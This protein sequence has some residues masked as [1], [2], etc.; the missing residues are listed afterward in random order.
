MDPGAFATRRQFLAVHPRPEQFRHHAAGRP[1]QEPSEH[2]LAAQRGPI[3]DRRSAAGAPTAWRGNFPSGSMSST[4]P[5]QAIRRRHCASNMT[6]RALS[7]PP[8]HPPGEKP[9]EHAAPRAGYSTTFARADSWRSCAILTPSARA[10]A[11]AR[12]SPSPTPPC[13]GRAHEQMLDDVN[14]PGALP[15]SDL[16]GFVPSRRPSSGVAAFPR[17]GGRLSSKRPGHAAAHSQY[18]SVGRADS[19]LQ[20]AE[21]AATLGRRCCDDRSHRGAVDGT[22]G[23]S[24]AGQ[25]WSAGDAVGNLRVAAVSKPVEHDSNRV[26]SQAITPMEWCSTGT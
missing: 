1:A 15:L 24:P 5:R 16:R 18:R 2:A 9:A 22:P 10:F 8:R 20:C 25:A 4:G 11:A 17:P 3:S 23:I 26:F 12:V 14:A 13:T 21:P 6:G 7:V 19:R